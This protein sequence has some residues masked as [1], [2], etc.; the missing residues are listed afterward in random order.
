MFSIIQQG[1]RLFTIMSATMQSGRANLDANHPPDTPIMLGGPAPVSSTPAGP[2]IS[3]DKQRELEASL[4]TAEKHSLQLGA[5][6]SAEHDATVALGLQAMWLTCGVFVA[7]RGY[8]FADPI[9]SFVKPYTDNLI[10]CKLMNP[11][12]LVGSL[13]ASV[14]AYQVPTDVTFWLEARKA[15]AAEAKRLEEL[16]QARERTLQTLGIKVPRPLD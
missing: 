11:F 2:L 13:M 15:S 10:L 9:R 16:T 5:F 4:R 7:R 12:T 3:V 6:R 14:T 1:C 8:K